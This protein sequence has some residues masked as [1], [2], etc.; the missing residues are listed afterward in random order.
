MLCLLLK[1]PSVVNAQALPQ[2]FKV[3][4]WANV[5]LEGGRCRRSL[6]E[7]ERNKKQ[8]AEKN[9]SDLFRESKKGGKREGSSGLDRFAAPTCHTGASCQHVT[10]PFASPFP[11][12]DDSAGGKGEGQ[13][14]VYFDSQCM[15]ENPYLTAERICRTNNLV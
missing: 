12:A 5:S 15:I 7:L 10:P 3:S 4:A 11:P 14:S 9:R 2:G 13:V 1:I 6:K 8:K